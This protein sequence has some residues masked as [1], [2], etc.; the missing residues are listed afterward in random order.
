MPIC[1][2]SSTHT[3]ILL[4]QKQTKDVYVQK[5]IHF[6]FGIFEISSQPKTCKFF[7][8]REWKICAVSKVRRSII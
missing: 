6:D 1:K 7:K 3:N 5:N 4:T 8:N 2:L